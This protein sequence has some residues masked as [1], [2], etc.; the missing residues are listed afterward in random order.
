MCYSPWELPQ[1]QGVFPQ[2]HIDS[3]AIAELL[4]FLA[5]IA[6]NRSPMPAEVLDA[7]QQ[8]SFTFR[9]TAVQAMD[10]GQS[11]RAS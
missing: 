7:T 1:Q 2:E 8:G 5:Q 6:R 4:A 10:A 3:R 9:S 11:E